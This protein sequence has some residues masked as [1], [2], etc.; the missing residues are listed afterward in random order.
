[1]QLT[2]KSSSSASSLYLAWK[3]A[4]GESLV[5]GALTEAIA[6]HAAKL[7]SIISSSG[8][9]RERFWRF[10]MG[11]SSEY[12]SNRQLVEV[13]LSKLLGRSAALGALVAPLIAAIDAIEAEMTRLLPKLAQELPLRGGPL[14][15]QWEARGPG[16]LRRFAKLTEESVLAPQATVVVVHPA[17]AGGCEVYLEG[18]QVLC[19]GL[20]ANADP[21][22]P[23]VVR[24]GWSLV[25]LQMDLPVFS[26]NL[27]AGRLLQLARLA[28]L[29]PILKA[30]EEVEL[31]H[32]PSELLP[33]ALRHWNV[34]PVADD[35]PVILL[36]N[37]WW[38]D[39]QQ[40]R[41]PWHV[42]LMALDNLLGDGLL[43]SS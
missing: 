33:Q 39:Y 7:E 26:E 15:E 11:L 25:Q 2:W 29:P 12:P 4:Q 24:L 16:L 22:L 19:E 43:P 5:D 42:A 17:T 41:L 34:L 36:L 10:L 18:N 3:L 37:A 30:A 38:D 27:P 31:V 13:V 1:M 9:P 14:R 20:L 6:P 32:S 28:M 35:S 8:V 23:E 21:R 40:N